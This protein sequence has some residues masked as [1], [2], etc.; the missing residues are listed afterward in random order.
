VSARSGTQQS[1]VQKLVVKA[2][3]NAP[4]TLSLRDAKSTSQRTIVTALESENYRRRQ[5]AAGG[6]LR[7][8][9]SARPG[10]DI[11][12]RTCIICHGENF[13]PTQAGDPSAP[14]RCASTACMGAQ[15]LNKTGGVLR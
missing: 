15:L 13:L 14:G 9:L 11:A 3:D 5:R 7:R 6:K 8:S 12:E 4:V 1:E 10:R 2:G